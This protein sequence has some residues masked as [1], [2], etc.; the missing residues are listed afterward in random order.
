MFNGFPHLTPRLINMLELQG[1]TNFVN[2]DLLKPEDGESKRTFLFSPF[3]AFDKAEYY[4]KRLKKNVSPDFFTVKNPLQK[5]RLM[6]IATDANRQE[7]LVK[8]IEHN[9]KLGDE[10]RTKIAEYIRLN[11]PQHFDSMIKN[12]FRIIIGDNF[13]EIFYKIRIGAGNVICIN[14]DEL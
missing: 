7:C 11:Y 10:E 3:K 9:Y 1:Y 5:K 2:Q 6:E 14:D 12:N 13:G 4:C 8:I